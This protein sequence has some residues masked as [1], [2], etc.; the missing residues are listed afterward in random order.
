MPKQKLHIEYTQGKKI[1]WKFSMASLLLCDGKLYEFAMENIV[2][3]QAKNMASFAAGV[4]INLPSHKNSNK[5]HVFKK[6][7]KKIM[8]VIT[9][10]D[11][12]ID[13]LVDV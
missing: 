7:N 13:I 2:V 6:Q 8:V 1:G 9:E 11:L 12:L 10:D 5:C 3:S 4:H